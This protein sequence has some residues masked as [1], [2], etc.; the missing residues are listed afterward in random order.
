MHATPSTRTS[1]RLL[2]VVAAFA[3]VYLVW[4]STYLV[5][6]IGLDSLPPFVM[7]GVRFL[8]AGAA[9]FAWARISGAP[10]PRTIEWRSAALVG[11]PMLCCSHGAVV[12]S[13]TRVASSLVA[14]II[15]VV[16]LWMALFEWV[17]V[18]R[19]RPSW[20]VFVGLACGFVGVAWLMSPSTL[21]AGEPV[22]LAGAAAVVFGS[23]GWAAGSLYA[24]RAT[25]PR[26]AAMGTAMEMLAGGAGLALMATVAGE[27]PRVHVAEVTTASWLALGYL[28]VFGSLL[29]FSAYIWLLRHVGAG[30]AATYAYVNPVVAVFLGW[31]FGHE[32]LGPRHWVASALVIVAV[33]VIT[34][35]RRAPAPA[36]IAEAA[37]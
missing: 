11:V 18:T 15:G 28:I 3:A 20:Q 26:S 25:L 36:V 1:P 10:W 32:V 23:A 33:V 17:F 19:R 29:A 27:W 30:R 16:P 6:R 9:L 2:A 7:A 13:E 14:V 5:I 34:T 35:A 8:T 4:G 31:A 22:N 24:R 12:W 37:A 21:M